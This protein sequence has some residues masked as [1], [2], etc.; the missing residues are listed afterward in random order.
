MMFK[1]VLIKGA[2]DIASGIA[3]RLHHCGY[4]IIMTDI[5]IPTTV[6]RTVAFSPA[7]YL[8]KAMV[9]D[10][11]GLYCRSLTEAKAA[12]MTGQLAIMTDEAAD[13][14]DSWKPEVV[15]DAILAKRN[16]GTKITDAF[17]VIGIGPGFTAGLD[18]HCV[19]ESMRGH[20]LGRCIWSGEAIPN[21]G[22]PGS[23]GGYGVERLVR[24]TADGIFFGTV[25]IGSRVRAG[26]LLG[27]A[28]EAPVYARIDG[29]VRG[30]L[31]DGVT[32]FRGMK[33]GD[34]DPR[35]EE[36]HCFTVSDKARSIGGGVLEAI[37]TIQ[38]E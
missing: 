11:S 27:Y 28:G 23:I 20:F 6:R 16:L 9:E 7:I 1:K 3:L 22:V 14:Q 29:I 5:L 35:C 8:A 30:L 12:I 13:I 37:L 33:T 25:S 2:G 10:V 18:C 24:A 21:T 38:R 17:A 4:Q 15:V 31:Q 32:V 26:D 36:S 19:I 34:V